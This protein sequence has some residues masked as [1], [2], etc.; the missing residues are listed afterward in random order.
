MK[1]KILN[2]LTITILQFISTRIIPIAVHKEELIKVILY[3]LSIVSDN[4][5]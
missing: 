3:I 5:L 2:I 1:F 4:N